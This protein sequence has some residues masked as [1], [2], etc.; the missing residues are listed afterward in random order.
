[1]M[2]YILLCLI[3]MI[4]LNIPTVKASDF[5]EPR[6]EG[7]RIWIGKDEQLDWI[8]VCC[9]WGDSE[10]GLQ[11]VWADYTPIEEVTILRT[12]YGKTGVSIRKK[13]SLW[14]LII[15]LNNAEETFLT[16]LKP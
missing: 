5:W 10:D 1:M 3:G 4:C 16:R 12:E 11:L 9:E 14:N 15:Y 8:D 7:Y 13:H 6:I 2:R